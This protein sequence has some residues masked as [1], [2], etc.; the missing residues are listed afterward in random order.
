MAHPGHYQ[1]FQAGEGD[2]ADVAQVTWLR[3]LENIRKIETRTAWASGWRR[4]PGTSL[5]CLAARKRV[6]LAEDDTVLQVAA[7]PGPEVD[8]RLLSAEQSQIV[9]DALSRLPWRVAADARAAHGG[10]RLPT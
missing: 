5:R 6:V 3:L 4:P 7:T 10:S 1:G 2:A 8:E 9:R